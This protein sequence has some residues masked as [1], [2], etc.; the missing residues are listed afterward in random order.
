ML[1]VRCPNCAKLLQ[2]VETAT[3]CDSVC[4]ACGNVFQPERALGTPTTGLHE[5]AVRPYVPAAETA[6]TTAAPPPD[7]A[8]AVPEHR[9]SHH[10][11]LENRSPPV[12]GLGCVGFL[13]GCAACALLSL[14]MD[15]D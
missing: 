2:A 5:E 6:V 14:R 3:D 7:R 4:P 13:G 11:W 10:L 12:G 9:R 15:R 1:D 8:A